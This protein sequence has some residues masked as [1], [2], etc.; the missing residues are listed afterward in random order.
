M[1]NTQRSTAAGSSERA[2]AETAVRPRPE[3][4][5][6]APSP[7]TPLSKAR[8]PGKPT[9][10][11]ARA[12][13]ERAATTAQRC[14]ALG[15]LFMSVLGS[16]LAFNGGWKS[17]EWPAFWQGLNQLAAVLGIGV[18]SWLTLMQWHHRHHKRSFAYLSHLAIDAC[19]TYV[20][21]AALLVP[22]FANGLANAGVE[23][24]V[25]AQSRVLVG[26][27]AIAIAVI[28]ETTLVD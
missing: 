27:I 20:G 1:L 7:A 5:Q 23:V 10:I 28:P 18:Q 4:N 12:T 3:G 17:V 24:G 21:Y 11:V 19:L 14:G 16:V 15:L 8:P 13:I 2:A 9:A 25:D 6:Q 22:L 26:I